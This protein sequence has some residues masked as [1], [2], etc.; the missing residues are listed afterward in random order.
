MRNTEKSCRGL[1]SINSCLVSLADLTST[2]EHPSKFAILEDTLGLARV[3][4]RLV[5]DYVDIYY[6]TP[7]ALLADRSVSAF[8]PS[9]LTPSRPRIRSCRSGSL[10]SKSCTDTIGSA[11]RPTAFRSSPR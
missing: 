9:N 10:S 2:P 6:P 7:E 11:G 3:V 5:S 4:H 1:L 8:F